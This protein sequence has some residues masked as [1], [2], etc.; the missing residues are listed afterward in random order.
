MSIVEN[1]LYA[2]LENDAVEISKIKQDLVALRSE[3][4]ISEQEEYSQ[5]I[6]LGSGAITDGISNGESIQNSRRDQN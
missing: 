4:E 1:S 2:G 5:S 6:E 3:I